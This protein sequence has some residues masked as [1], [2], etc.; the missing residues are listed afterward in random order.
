MTKEAKIMLFLDERDEALKKIDQEYNSRYAA[1]GITATGT[2][3]LNMW[4]TEERDKIEKAFIKNV[5]EL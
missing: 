3:A 2:I 4:H 5:M 1:E